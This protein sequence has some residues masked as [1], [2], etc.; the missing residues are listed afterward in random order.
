[1]NKLIPMACMA[2]LGTAG[3]ALA[4]PQSSD[5][6]PAADPTPSSTTTGKPTRQAASGKAVPAAPSIQQITVNGAR[7]LDTG[8]LVQSAAAAAHTYT[9][10]GIRYEMKL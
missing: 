7:S 8:P 5:Q 4:L 6:A 9:T 2:L 10:F 1:M 3:H